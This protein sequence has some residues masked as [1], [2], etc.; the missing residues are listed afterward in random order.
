M[1]QND[2]PADAPFWKKG[3]AALTTSEWEQ[4]CDGCGRCCLVKLEDE[5]TDRIYF[6]SVG[7][8]LLDMQSC[9]C[10]NYVGRK[11]HVPECIKLTPQKVDE[12]SWLPPS[13]A[14]RLVAEG[15]DLMWWHPLVSG[16]FE[17]VH[18]AGISV[19]GRVV[20]LESEVEPDDLQDYLVS[21][22]MRI[23]KRAKQ[24]L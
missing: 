17:T 18:Q 10:T 3:L 14:Y 12:I 15:K 21:W 19:R 9:R 11:R 7:C 24:K 22:P 13:C 6:T 2:N 1:S 4:L 23:P 20:A 16:S 8:K 5:D